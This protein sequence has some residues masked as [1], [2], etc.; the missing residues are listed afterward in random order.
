MGAEG[1]FSECK[2]DRRVACQNS[3]DTDSSRYECQ[4]QRCI[5]HQHKY[6]GEMRLP[7]LPSGGT[8]RQ[9]YQ[10]E[11][12]KK[13]VEDPIQSLETWSISWVDVTHALSPATFPW[14][15]SIGVGCCTDLSAKSINF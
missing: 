14:F 3:L 11:E 8:H 5:H 6:I 15:D 10:C 12:P 13:A 1:G 9:R 4:Y 7:D 2:A